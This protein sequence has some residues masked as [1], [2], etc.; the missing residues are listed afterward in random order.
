MKANLLN[1]PSIERIRQVLAYD[2]ETGIL[3]W[4]I[5]S[6]RAIAGNEA[7]HLDKKTGYI[8]VRIDG[9]FIQAHHVCWALEF[10]YWPER[11]DHRHGKEAGNGIENLRECTQSQN[12]G[13][14][15]L[16]KHNTSGVKGVNFHKASGQWAAQ[17]TIDGKR[18]YLGVRPTKEGAAA[19]YAGAANA[20]FGSD[21]SMTED[22]PM[23]TARAPRRPARAKGRPTADEVR[24]VLA[25]DRLTGVLKWKQALSFRGPIGSE[26]GRL[27]GDGYRRIGL[28]GRYYQAH[29]LAWTIATGRWPTKIIDHEN[30]IRSHNFWDNLSEVTQSQNI[31]AAYRRGAYLQAA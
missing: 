18:T 21:F 10:G 1:R 15:G 29:I 2:R 30:R 17:I 3:T 26:A 22:R 19:L 27:M 8:R 9:C 13:N 24:A 4:R 7:G 16:P 20:H 23:V 11:L 5:T 31:L 28:Y 6:G 12:M 25:Y 14:I